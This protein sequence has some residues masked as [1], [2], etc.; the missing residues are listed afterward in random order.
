MDKAD[1]ISGSDDVDEDDSEGQD[2]HRSYV[3]ERRGDWNGRSVFKSSR[4]VS[5]HR[6]IPSARDRAPHLA[7]PL[8]APSYQ[9]HPTTRPSRA[10]SLAGCASQAH[11]ACTDT[12][13]RHLGEAGHWP[14]AHALALDARKTPGGLGAIG[15]MDVWRAEVAGFD[16]FASSSAARA[17]ADGPPE[18]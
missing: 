16:C 10:A 3:W 4:A 7:T 8:I 6:D 1:D 11:D 13:A 18:P 15:G 2:E 14:T 5:I 12:A 17:E 9:P